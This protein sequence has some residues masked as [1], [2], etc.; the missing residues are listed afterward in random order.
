MNILVTGS[1]GF[2]GKS[3]IKFLNEK[4]NHKVFK[5]SKKNYLIEIENNIKNLDFVFHFAGINRSD[6]KI[7]FEKVNVVLTKKIC[8]ILSRNPNTTLVYASSTQINLKNDYGKS[9]KRAEQI[10]L[11]L[12]KRFNN[13]VHILRLPGIFGIGCKPNYNSV[14]AT[15]CFNTA[16]KIDLNIINPCKE[17]ELLFIEDLCDQL[18]NLII[19]KDLSK[20]S[21]VKLKKIHKISIEDL[22]K[23]IKSFQNNFKT[24]YFFESENEL[25]KNLYKT[26][27]S[28]IKNN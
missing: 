16:K 4:T 18:N 23:T 3:F 28:F 13:R 24:N 9:K 20:L 25:E 1:N 5:F 11:D 19:K 2:L 8:G 17:I 26:Y 14:V 7:N 15:F 6:E 21:L 27:M 22:A 10:C 12:E